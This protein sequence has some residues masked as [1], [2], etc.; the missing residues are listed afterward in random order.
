MKSIFGMEQPGNINQALVNTPSVNQGA[1]DV[2]GLT[3]EAQQEAFRNYQQKVASQNALMSSIMGSGTKI[4]TA[5][6]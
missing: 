2:A 5:P 6:L 4:L 3:T 1:T